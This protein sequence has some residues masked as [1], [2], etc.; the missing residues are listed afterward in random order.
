M[1]SL[2]RNE[3]M[4]F[5]VSIIM[6]QITQQLGCLFNS[7]FRLTPQKHQKFLITGLLWV[8]DS[9]HKGPVMQELFHDFIISM[10][11][12]KQGWHFSWYGV[13]WSAEWW[14]SHCRDTSPH[15]ELHSAEGGRLPSSAKLSRMDWECERPIVRDVRGLRRGGAGPA[16]D[17]TKVKVKWVPGH[18]GDKHDCSAVMMTSVREPCD[19]LVIAELS[20]APT[21]CNN[22]IMVSTQLFPQKDIMMLFWGNDNV[23]YCI[24]CFLGTRQAVETSRR[25]YNLVPFSVT[26]ECS[27]PMRE[28]VTY[29]TSYLIGWEHSCMTCDHENGSNDWVMAQL[30]PSN[31]GC[32]DIID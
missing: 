10:A 26:R 23:K 20:Q 16:A 31:T 1:A 28:D 32:F 5:H 14:N 22:G 12:Y 2:D 30:Q 19:W 13:S 27:Q 17:N 8:E 18:G 9:P 11:E 6:S 25:L 29:V 15:P 3:L 24:M 21:W 4:C 7:L